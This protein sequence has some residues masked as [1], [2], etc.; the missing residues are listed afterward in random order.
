MF[1]KTLPVIIAL[2]VLSITTQAQGRRDRDAYYEEREERRI[3]R[4]ER[5]R[6]EREDRI[7]EKE[8]RKMRSLKESSNYGSN[9]IRLAP[10]RVLDIGGIGFGLEYERLFGHENMLGIVLPF[11]V[12]LEE[13]YNSWNAVDNNIRYNPSFYFNPGLKIYPFGQRKVTYAVGPSLM[14]GYGKSDEWTW[15]SS[16][17]W[18]STGYYTEVEKSRFNFGMIVM[19]YVNFQITPSFS[20]GFDAGLGIRYL[21]HQKKAGYTYNNGIEPTGQVSLTLGFRF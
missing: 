16:D 18:G 6:Q 12:M 15:V 21:S 20:L 4:E 8:E 19:N 7:A 1:K 17:P 11:T 3:R 13:E 9:F 14:F 5:A 10:F 2:V